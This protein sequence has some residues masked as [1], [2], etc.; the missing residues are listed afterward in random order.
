[1]TPEDLVFY[2]AND[3]TLRVGKPAGTCRGVK[4]DL[5]SDRGNCRVVTFSGVPL[6]AGFVVQVAPWVI[7]P[8]LVSTAGKA[9]DVTAIG[10]VQLVVRLAF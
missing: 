9:K 1:M 7:G 4:N 8:N 5:A 3:V 10:E 6:E 2:V